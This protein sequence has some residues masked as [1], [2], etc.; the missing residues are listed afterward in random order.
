MSKYKT[1]I[2]IETPRGSREKYDYDSRYGM[3]CLKKLLP[4]GMVFPFD[5]GFIPG[6]KGEDGDPLD[7][8]VLSS[9][10]TFPGCMIECR[11]LGAIKAVQIEKDGEKIRNDRYLFTPVV[12]GY[13]WNTGCTGELPEK[14]L[15][16]LEDFFINYNRE[17][18]KDFRPQG[19]INA[20][21]AT[22]QIKKNEG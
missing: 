22:K 7:A 17:E 6:T 3:L 5:F 4:E 19:F 21:E 9:L 11:L 18:G 1:F 16:E 15:R 14:L 2:I 20:K 10:K 12:T 8:F 13:E